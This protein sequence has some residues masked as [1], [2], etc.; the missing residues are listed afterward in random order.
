[1]KMKNPPIPKDSKKYPLWV[2]ITIPTTEA[3]MLFYTGKKHPDYDKYCYSCRAWKKFEKTGTI[4]TLVE[5]RKDVLN[6]DDF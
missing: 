2:P 6:I 1:M 3:E 4:D 5:R